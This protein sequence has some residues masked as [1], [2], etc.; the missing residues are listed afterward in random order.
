[1][2]VR[3]GA[4]M[5]GPLTPAKMLATSLTAVIVQFGLAIILLGGWAAFFSHPA[6]IALAAA[7]LGLLFVAP[8]SNANLSSG[9]KEDR[10]NRWVFTAISVVAFGSAIVPPYADR[11]GWW[12]IDGETTRWV[13]VILYVLGGVLRLWPV[14]VL[15]FRFSGLVAIQPGHTLETRG[16][17]RLIRNPSYLGMIVNMIGWGLAF[18]GWSGVVIALFL[19]VPLIPRMHAE[20]RLLHEHFGAEYDAYL[21]RTWRLIPG[22]Y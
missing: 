16:I 1:M 21:A 3:G 5:K 20:E 18:R 13:G 15:G 7:T 12:T 17:Y 4:I 10:A 11:A 8:F 14:F 22:I 2:I 9:E 19:L 6:L